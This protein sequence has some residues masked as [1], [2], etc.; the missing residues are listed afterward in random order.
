MFKVGK[1]IKYGVLQSDLD[2]SEIPSEGERSSRREQAARE[3]VN[4]DG[5]ERSRRRTIGYFSTVLTGVIYSTN[6]YFHA[7]FLLR[8]ASLYFPV[9]LSAGFLKSADEGLWNVAQGGLWDVEG[10]GLSRIKNK[11]LALKLLDKTNAMNKKIGVL[12]IGITLA[13]A[14]TPEI[15]Q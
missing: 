2:P 11:D 9:A 13:L 8:V 15:F 14:I 5:A 7:P 1:S 6:L 12:S 10:A 4:I 3:L